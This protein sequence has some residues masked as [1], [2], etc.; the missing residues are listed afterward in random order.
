MLGRIASRKFTSKVIGSQSSQNI[1]VSPHNK[2]QRQGIEG[3]VGPINSFNMG[4]E[5]FSRAWHQDKMHPVIGGKGEY[6]FL[7]LLIPA[8]I[9]LKSSRTKNEDGIRSALGNST[10]RYAVFTKAYPSELW[11]P[12]TSLSLEDQVFK[13]Q[14]T[15]KTSFWNIS[16]KS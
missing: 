15:N 1:N 10:N 6:L 3:Q 16:K 8:V 7:A 4:Y 12:Q 2:E 11:L 9:F 13:N 14:N 5:G